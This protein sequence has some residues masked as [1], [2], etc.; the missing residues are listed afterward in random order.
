MITCLPLAHWFILIM[1]NRLPL[2]HLF[3][4]CPLVFHRLLPSLSVSCPLFPS[5]ALSFAFLLFYLAYRVFYFFITFQYLTYTPFLTPLYRRCFLMA[6]RFFHWCCVVGFQCV[7]CDLY[8]IDIYK[9]L[10]FYF[11]QVEFHMYILFLPLCIL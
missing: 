4:T 5:L 6:L 9:L 10:I 1:F 11:I 3:T 7:L 2:A 8:Y